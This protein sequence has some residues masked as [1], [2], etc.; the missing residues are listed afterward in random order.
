[1]LE[2]QKINL[3]NIIKNSLKFLV[4]EWKLYVIVLS[5]YLFKY[6][7]LGQNY[8]TSNFD[9]T[10]LRY[11]VFVNEIYHNI[12]YLLF[13]CS[14]IPFIILAVKEY[15]TKQQ[16]IS[17]K[18]DIII[19]YFV[20]LFTYQLLFSGLDFLMSFVSTLFMFNSTIMP[21]PVIKILLFV[22]PLFYFILGFIL[23]L[24]P[25]IIVLENKT[26]IDVTKKSVEIIRNKFKE[27]VT[28]YLILAIVIIIP[29]NINFLY[30]VITGK[31]IVIPGY[32]Y[33]QLILTSGWFIF[34]IAAIVGFYLIISEDRKFGYKN[35]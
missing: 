33:L 13:W 25:V 2:M 26:F 28:F 9:P 19:R 24:A 31:V 21:E 29:N 6:F 22:L 4:F 20:P 30:I 3:K 7:M 10:Q 8:S 16:R 11:E 35:Q 12:F 34:Y 5:I 27:C 18:K 1:M 17:F 14:I 15:V 32:N 23:F